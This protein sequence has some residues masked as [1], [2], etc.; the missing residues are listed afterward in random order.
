MFK[1]NHCQQCATVCHECANA[2]ANMQG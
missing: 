2:C 1:D